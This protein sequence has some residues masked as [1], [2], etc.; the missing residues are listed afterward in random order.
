MGIRPVFRFLLLL[1]ALAVVGGYATAWASREACI[2]ATWHE[3]AP[4]RLLSHPLG[5]MERPLARDDLEARVI[6]PFRVE[7]SYLVPN[8]L[9]STVYARHYATLPWKRTLVS[10]EEHRINSAL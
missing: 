5:E 8:G 1:L 4:R 2:D 10:S 7:V 9:E 3:L 6:A